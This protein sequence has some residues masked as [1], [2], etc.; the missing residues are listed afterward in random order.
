MYT[1]IRDRYNL[2]RSK[3]LECGEVL[4]EG[5]RKAQEQKIYE[6]KSVNSDLITEYDLKLEKILCDEI[7]SKF[8][9]DQILGEESADRKIDYGRPLWIIDPI[10]G[11]TNFAYGHDTFAISVAYSEQNTVLFGIVYAP[12]LNQIYEAER[13]NGA[14]LNGAK[15]TIAPIKSLS[16]VL[17]A[18]GIPYYNL[19]QHVHNMRILDRVVPYVRDM[20]S[21]GCASLEITDVAR[22][23]L[24]AF[25][26]SVQPW[27]IA[28]AG[29][30]AREAGAIT[31]YH[32][33]LHGVYGVEREK[34]SKNF[35][36]YLPEDLISNN[37][38][39][40]AP[41]IFEKLVELMHAY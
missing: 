41:G 9:D 15:I 18:T 8:P 17:F 13:G 25:Y 34:S 35:F 26:E 6:Q 28:A 7:A 31:G 16:E 12:N 20:R 4:K 39:V 27:D 37:Y 29:L 19:A 23:R 32:S 24:G 36:A 30:I 5:S 14:T 21:Y 1:E 40:A 11:T 3:I 2:I 38:L 10:D 22:G 33:P